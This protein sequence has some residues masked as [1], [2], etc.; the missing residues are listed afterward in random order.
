MEAIIYLTPSAA[1]NE[2]Y[3]KLFNVKTRFSGPGVLG[4]DNETITKQLQAEV[5]FFPL[6]IIIHGIKVFVATL[7]SSDQAELNFAGPGYCSSFYYKYHG[8]YSL[9]C[10]SIVNTGCRIDIYHQEK[11]VQTYTGK[12]PTDVWTN[13]NI[14]KNFD[15]RDLFGLCDQFVIQAIRTYMNTPYCKSCDWNNIQIMTHAFEK[16][17]K[18]RISVVNVNW[19]QFFAKWKQQSTTII[20]FTSHLASI[21]PVNYEVTNVILGAWRAMMRYVGC[22]DITPY[23]KKESSLEFWTYAEDSTS[24]GALI[25]YLYTKNLLNGIPY[26]PSKSEVLVKNQELRNKVGQFWN[27]FDTSIKINKRGLEGK[28]RILSVIANDFG[29]QEIKEK[30]NISNDLMNAARKYSRTNG[31]GCIAIYEGEKIQTA[32]V[33]LGG[34]SVANLEPIRDNHKVKTIA[35]ITKLFYFEWPVDGD[36]AGYI[37]AQCLPHI[38]SCSQFSPFEISKLTTTPVNKPISNT[39]PHSIPKNPWVFSLSRVQNANNQEKDNNR[40]RLLFAIEETFELK[41]GWAL[42]SNQKYGTR[43]AGKR[44]TKIVKAYL[45]SYFLAGNMNR[46]DRMTAKDMV[47]Q[48]Q[49]LA[50]EGE[51]DVED[52]PEITTVASWITRYAASLK[53]QSAIEKVA[54]GSNTARNTNNFQEM[55]KSSGEKSCGWKRNTN[56]HSEQVTKRQKKM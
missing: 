49:I 41:R 18:K 44:M 22:T 31:P 56:S 17:L 12:S 20:E 55:V 47:E 10:Q 16:C 40:V 30:L 23:K 39:T 25:L 43:G 33:D 53:K 34:T 2:T 5:L 32:I 45:E 11:K 15:G 48:L 28:Q 26:D 38:G 24:D 13:L 19:Y 50:N 21:Y 14:L 6:Q 42:K 4:F 27:C 1:I 8:Q 54:E 3:K 37:R 46:T 35:G 51:I 36:Y 9:I 52:V 29:R 7:G